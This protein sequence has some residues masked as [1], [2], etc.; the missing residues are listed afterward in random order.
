MSIVGNS[1]SPVDTQRGF[2]SMFNALINEHYSI[3]VDNDRR[4]SVLEHALS[5]TDFSIVTSIYMLLSNLNL[6]IFFMLRIQ[7]KNFDKLHRH[8]NWLK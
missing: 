3:S 5:K 2:K 6:R 4:Q 8:E 7:Q 1:G